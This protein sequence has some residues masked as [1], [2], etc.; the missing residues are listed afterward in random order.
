MIVGTI[1]H[2]LLLGAGGDVVIVEAADWRTKEAKHH[3][4]VAIAAHKLP[5]TR[6]QFDR[7]EGMYDAARRFLGG[8]MDQPFL[9]PNGHAELCCIASDPTGATLRTL[10]DWYGNKLSGG[11]EVWDY[12]TTEGSAN[13][14]YAQRQER[15]RAFQNA[16]HE[17]VIVIH[18]PELAGTIKFRNLIQDQH[19][20]YLCS[21]IEP[22]EEAMS[23]ARKMVAAAIGVWNQCMSSD[24]WPGYPRTPTRV[25][26]RSG[27]EQAWLQRELEEFS[28]IINNDPFLGSL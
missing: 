2:K 24:R 10:F 28:D 7:A 15:E 25:N 1:A 12:K 20:P 19:A 23:I 5:C 9:A 22:T 14:L 6:P 13:P 4:D 16:F 17:R 3:R 26:M 11:L 8:A 21:V 27:D 18:K